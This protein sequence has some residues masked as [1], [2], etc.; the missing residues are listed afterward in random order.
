MRTLILLP[1]LTL[2]I[3]ILSFFQNPNIPLL[4]LHIGL[5]TE[6]FFSLPV[7]GLKKKKKKKALGK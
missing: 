6:F 3:T 4:K 1:F 5:S 2:L 7:Q